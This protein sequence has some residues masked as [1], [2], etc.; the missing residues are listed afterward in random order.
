[1]SEMASNQPATKRSI[2]SGSDVDQRWARVDR[3]SSRG[4]YT[5]KTNQVGFVVHAVTG[6]LYFFLG[7]VQ[8]HAPTRQ[9]YPA[10][11]RA[12][13]WLY[14]IFSVIA[15]AGVVVILL[16]GSMAGESAILASALYLPTWLVLQWLAIR[17]IQV[18]D[19]ALHRRHQLRA[20]A[21][22]CSVMMMRPVAGFIIAFTVENPNE[23]V[24][25]GEALKTALWFVFSLTV[26]FTEAFLVWEDR[27]VEKVVVVPSSDKS[28]AVVPLSH[29]VSPGTIASV[30]VPPAHAVKSVVVTELTPRTVRAILTLADG[31]YL[32][33]PGQHVAVTATQPDSLIDTSLTREYSPVT[34]P[35]RAL[36]QHEVELVIR[37]V[38]GGAMSA[39]WRTPKQWNWSVTFVPVVPNCAM[40]R[41]IAAKDSP[42][43][44]V[45]LG[46]GATPF[47]NVIRALAAEGRRV[48][49][50]QVHRAIE[51]MFW[52]ADEWEAMG[53]DEQLVTSEQRIGRISA[54]DLVEKVRELDG[55]GKPEAAGWRVLVSGPQQAVRELTLATRKAL[56]W[57]E[58]RVTAVGLDDR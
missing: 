37:L 57:E 24:H 19:V 28:I 7:L 34:H 3:F 38:P 31:P 11:H 15:A 13:G 47:V 12:A 18:G 22:A 52:T 42:V 32:V 8:F 17:A 43:L 54:Q 2:P 23:L 14:T 46:T 58:H 25:P 45:S 5:N 41:A 29:V 4:G 53:V 49:V 33:V 6:S 16:G 50:V 36:S 56:G 27:A 35:S 30:L 9:A 20:F 40:Q 51:D 39:R 1:M 55:K 21:I 48:H 10:F 44:L 26:A